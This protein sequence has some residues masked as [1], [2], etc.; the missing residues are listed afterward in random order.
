VAVNALNSAL[1]ND[2]TTVVYG[3]SQVALTG[4]TEGLL[5]LLTAMNEGKV[6]T[7]IIHGVNPVYYL[8]DNFTKALAKVETVVYAGTH[9]D[10]TAIKADFVATDHHSV[11]AWGDSEAVSGVYA[12]QQPTI[13]PMYNTRSALMG[14][15]RWADATTAL[16]K[17]ETDFDAVQTFWKEKVTASVGAS[18]FEDFWLEILQKGSVGALKTERDPART[19]KVDKLLGLKPVTKQGYEL[20]L[21]PTIQM[22]QGELA[23]IGWLQELPDP[24]TKIVWDNYASVSIGTAEK[25]KLSEGDKIELDVN[26][27]KMIVP[28]HVQPGLHDDVVAISLGYGR[29]HAGKIGSGIGVNAYPMVTQQNGQFVFAGEPLTIK[30]TGE[31]YVLANVQGHHSMEGRAIVV[32]AT[33]KEYLQNKSAGLHKHKIFS[34]WPYHRYD[35]HK[36]AM[37]L[38][39]NLCTGCSACV[40][41]CQSENNVPIVGKTYVLQGREMHW[42]RIDRYYTGDPSDAE[43]VFQPVMCQHCDNAPCETVCPVLATVHSN[44]GLNEMVYNRCVGTRY[45]VN[46]CPYKV[47][48]FNWFDYRKD[49]NKTEAMAFNPEVGVRVRGVMEKCTFCVQRI[50][51]VKDVVRQEGRTLVDGELKA[52]CQQTC[53]T[54]AIVFGDV[55]DPKSQVSKMFKEEPRSYSL[56]E[57]F[58]AA[59]A[60]R[61]LTKIRN[62]N[63]RVINP[64][65]E[66]GKKGDHV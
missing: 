4:S 42:I 5:K 2:G 64:H 56:L 51:T 43:T 20:L 15:A 21:Y 49:M 30:A 32:E 54:G 48:R 9:M 27:T 55:N 22:G 60:V 35:G 28:A 13:R 1:G 39:L 44:E 57:E 31:K 33:L 7:L 19:P 41:A 62:N 63:E 16:A 65:H 50:K 34:I 47:R 61:Y 59:P 26:G 23:N 3:Q 8:G 38:D 17:S 10:E 18:S 58:H 37:S 6:K 36:W 24:V 14:F 11:E 66:D 53:P 45:C 40:V 25:L 46:N 52:A 12:I 29:T